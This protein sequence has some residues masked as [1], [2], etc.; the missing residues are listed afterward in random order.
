[1][2][3]SVA[4][5]I[6]LVVLVLLV[7]FVVLGVPF[8]VAALDFVCAAGAVLNVAVVALIVK[9]TNKEASRKTKRRESRTT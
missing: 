5:V 1:M 9:Q 7:A 2:R 4:A 6:A 8:V 3:P